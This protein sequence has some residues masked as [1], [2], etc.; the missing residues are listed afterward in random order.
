MT[1]TFAIVGAGLAGAKAAETLRTEGFDGRVVLFGDEPDRPYERP[2][3]SKGYLRGEDSVDKV[4]VHDEVFYETNDIDLRT[5]TRVDALDLHARRL[6][7]PGN[8]TLRFDALLLATGSAPR[9]PP[10]PGIDLY[11]VHVLRTLEDS[12]RL[13]HALSTAAHVVIVG[14]GW[15]GCEVAASARQLGRQVTVV[16]PLPT[17]LFRVLGAEV[18]AVFGE[19]HQG[20][21]VTLRLGVGVERFLGGTM[22]EAVILSDGTRVEADVVVVG[23]GV[24]PRI[25]LAAAA[26][27]S[28]SE[29]VL[30]DTFLQTSAEG[31]FVAG[32]IAAAR[33]P[34]LDGRV[35]VEHWA[36]A[37]NQGQQAAKNML[38]AAEAYDRLPYF[39][40][41]QYDVGLEYAGH[42]MSWDDVVFRGDVGNHEFVA[43]YRKDGRVVAGIAVNVE[44]V[45]DP[46]KALIGSRAQPATVALRDPSVDLAGLARE[47]I[48]Q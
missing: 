47:A 30:A 17:P 14:A 1:R 41:D 34:F 45:M 11:G 27:L 35:R 16:D 10:I 40:S 3:L 44:G 46:I 2:P 38:G 20:H 33:H 4:F 37:L 42:A 21:G 22:V 13:R 7:L 25:E 48:R 6:L 24:T 5:G 12:R 32:D 28:V 15:I 9:R 8:G 29:G 36:N 31:V 19:L 23:V 43:L 18:G 26:G 39:Y